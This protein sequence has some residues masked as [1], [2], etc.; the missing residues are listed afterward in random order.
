MKFACR[1]AG[2]MKEAAQKELEEIEK[3]HEAFDCTPE[4]HPLASKSSNL[5]PTRLK[6]KQAIAA[7]GCGSL[8]FSGGTGD[9]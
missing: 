9:L 5:R 1:G 8:K 4:T 2:A 6:E 3:Q 7:R